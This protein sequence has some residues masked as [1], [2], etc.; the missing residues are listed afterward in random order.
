MSLLYYTEEGRVIPSL[1]EDLTRFRHIRKTLDLPATDGTA[2]VWILARCYPDNTAPLRLAVNGTEVVMSVGGERPGAYCWHHVD[3]DASALRAGANTFQLWTDTSAMDGWSIALEAGHANPG[4]EVSDDGGQSWRRE[5]MGYLNAVLGEHVLRVRLEEGQDPPPPAVVWENAASPRVA[6]LR[7]RLPS[8]ARGDAP[9]LERV[10]ALS[11]WLASSWE[12][13]GSGRAEQ[14]APWDAETLL[15][16][17]PQQRG[18]NGKRPI[19]MCVHYAAALV[20]AAQSVGIPARC[21]VLTETV[22]GVA[23]HFVAEVWEPELGKWVVVDPNTDAF[24]VRDGIPMSMTQIQQAGDDIGDFIEWGP[25]TEFQLTF[26]H[27]VEFA[28]GN[29][30]NGVCFRH[31]SVWHRADLL[32]SPW[33]SPPGHGSLSY[34]ETGLVW[35]RRDLD[36]GFGMFPAFGDAAWFD[37]PPA[38]WE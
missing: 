36:R 8:A 7:Q 32:T 29:L 20:S 30:K 6:S 33:M 35:E 16:W 3:V 34:C 1:G 23:G 17:A 10:R 25:G 9:V 18:H 19:A 24:F 12:H 11:S 26:P 31:R 2:R 5:R 21:A 4:S 28:E 27:I 37:A 22:N 14:Y 13:T 38:G 15:S